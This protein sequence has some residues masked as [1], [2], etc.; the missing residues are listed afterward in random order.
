MSR[1]QTWFHATNSHIPEKTRW[2]LLL[3]RCSRARDIVLA[4][5]Y[6][7]HDALPTAD[8]SQSKRSDLRPFG[9]GNFD[10][11]QGNPGT[12]IAGGLPWAIPSGQDG[13]AL[14]AEDLIPGTRN[15]EDRFAGADLTPRQPRWSLLGTARYQS[16]RGRGNQHRA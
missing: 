14:K 7:R 13:T 12:I 15:L 9:D 16:G 5:E 11:L 1:N 2:A 4:F 6:Y 10:V 8:R 3:C